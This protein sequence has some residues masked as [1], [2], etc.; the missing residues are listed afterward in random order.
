LAGFGLAVRK[1]EQR[2][3]I[4]TAERYELTRV[5]ISVQA[6]LDEAHV[7]RKVDVLQTLQ[8][9]HRAVGVEN[10]QLDTVACEDVAIFLGGAVERAAGYATRD[11]DR[12][13]RRRSREIES[14]SDP[15]RDD[16]EDRNQ[17]HPQ[18]LPG[19]A[20]EPHRNAEAGT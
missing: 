7:H 20:H 13:W 17:R 8:V 2:L 12:I 4:D 16:H 10:L 15:D 18:V 9:F 1:H 19:D 14:R 5:G 11:D 3:V 6:A